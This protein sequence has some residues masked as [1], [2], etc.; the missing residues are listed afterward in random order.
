MSDN[1]TATE[2]MPARELTP[3]R[4]L[5]DTASSIEKLRIAMGNRSSAIQRGVD[6]AEQPV[7]P[8]YAE[9]H[10]AMVALEER[11]DQAI[12]EELRNWPVWDSWLSH[13][14]GIGPSLAGQMLALLLP[15]RSDKGPSSW[16]KAAGLFSEARPD[17]T[18]RLPRARKGEGKFQ[19]HPWLRRCLYNVGTSFVRNGGYYREVYDQRKRRLFIQH[20]W[21][22]GELLTQWEAVGP[23]A[24]LDWLLTRY[25]EEA[26]VKAAKGGPYLDGTL[27]AWAVRPSYMGTVALAGISDETWPLGRVESVARWA[28]IKLFLSHLWQKWSEV[29]GIPVREP[30]AVEY[31]QHH[32]IDPPEWDGEHKI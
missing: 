18:N 14:R 19:H 20:C 7:P 2:E 4:Y 12:A 3:L 22:A 25:S 24:R 9:L 11:V 16:Y 17:G 6:G 29:E 5:H 10:R 32:R 1:G 26:L 21:A 15:P 13:V 8:V 28:T 23:D 30:Y 31:M 27:S